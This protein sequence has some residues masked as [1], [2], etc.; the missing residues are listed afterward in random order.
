VGTYAG[1][2]SS[3]LVLTNASG[4]TQSQLVTFNVTDDV[5]SRLVHGAHG[6]IT[7][8]YTQS[9]SFSTTS[10]LYAFAF[11]GYMVDV[12]FAPFSADVQNGTQTT[13]AASLLYT[14]P[15]SAIPEPSSLL[16]LGTAFLAVGG[17]L[18]RKIRP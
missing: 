4:A 15:P 3:N 14:D 1:S 5:T 11:P 16:L 17:I 8:V 9:F 18:R 7:T 2:A 12:T 13:A 6:S 10:P